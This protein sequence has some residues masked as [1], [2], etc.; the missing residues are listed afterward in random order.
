MR[1]TV[2]V[3][4]IVCSLAAALEVPREPSTST[5]IEQSSQASGI[6]ARYETKITFDDVHFLKRFFIW[7]GM[8]KAGYNELRF[9]FKPS[10]SQNT[11]TLLR[12]GGKVIAINKGETREQEVVAEQ[13]K[14]AR[15]E[16]VFTAPALRHLRDA[17]SQ[18]VLNRDKARFEYFDAFVIF[19][20]SEKTPD[21][22]SLLL[23][24]RETSD[25]RTISDIRTDAYGNRLGSAR[26]FSIIMYS[27]KTSA[28]SQAEVVGHANNWILECDAWVVSSGELSGAIMD[29]QAK[30]RFGSR[31]HLVRLK[32]KETRIIH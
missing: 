30:I 17:F 29:M 18:A 1:R 19:R 24:F 25:L 23:R 16:I 8:T 9:V 22:V 11:I 6:E 2:I 7:V 15:K 27:R 21:H 26:H 20:E 28:I 14:A 12:R 3:A 4:L 32:L 5:K 31:V 10:D 13:E